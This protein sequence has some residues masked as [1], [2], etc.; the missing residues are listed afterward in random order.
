[1]VLL[2]DHWWRHAAP[3][4]FTGKIGDFAWLIFAPFLLAV[5]LA[6]LLPRREKLVGYAA[7]IGVGL[8]FGLAKTVPAFHALTIAVL[9]FLTGWP[10]ILRLDPA[11]LI[12]LPA[13]LIAWWIWEKSATRSIRLPNRGWVLL[14]LA[15]L[16]TMA[17]SPAPNYG[18]ACLEQQGGQILANDAYASYASNDG[19]LS[20]TESSI[21]PHTRFCNMQ[22]KEVVAPANP[23]L[24]FQFTTEGLV[25]RSD[26]GGQTWQREYAVVPLSQAQSA[27]AEHAWNAAIV[28]TG[29]LNALVDDVTGNLI[30]AV[31]HEG[32]LVRTPD[33]AWHR[34]AVGP[35]R[36][37]DLHGTDKVV[38][39][40][41]G[42]VLLALVLIAL[43]SG[44]MGPDVFLARR[45]RNL[46]RFALLL[47]WLAW[48]G[49]LA[50]APPA[51]ASGYM[52]QMPIFGVIVAAAF[53]VPV[54]IRKLLAA[55]RLNA[56]VGWLTIGLSAL[57]ALLFLVPFVVWTQNGIP[58]Y[59]TAVAYAVVLVAVMCFV[60]QRYLRR[61]A[62]TPTNL[63]V[64]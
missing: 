59:S 30:M 17:D 61:N 24:R 8:I 6:W 43:A 60:G 58:H 39:L 48:L 56:K 14:P 45:S 15:V 52:K 36:V 53:A 28:K 22:P 42:E 33:G 16:A 10:N 29:P 35:Y 4:W 3:S 25:E 40:L 50:I 55:F 18:I 63:P 51:L 54:S 12:A 31:G 44:T 47:G 26:D 27:Y 1:V 19:G 37:I 38:S 13:L 64:A 5:I 9:E 21:E 49:T 23:R 62:I 46:L 32:V 20:W 2:N 57:T 11:D 34:A 7:I 41:A